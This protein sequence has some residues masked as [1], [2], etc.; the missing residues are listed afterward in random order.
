MNVQWPQHDNLIANLDYT[1]LERVV[2]VVLAVLEL[3]NGSEIVV[4]KDHYKTWVS[5]QNELVFNYF[6]ISLIFT[7]FKVIE[8][9]QPGSQIRMRRT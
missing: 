3:L 6:L 7:S 2:K 9:S 5:G 4:V 1:K 8:S